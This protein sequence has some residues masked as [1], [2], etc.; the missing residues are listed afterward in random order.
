MSGAPHLVQNAPH[1][2]RLWL[3]P[4][5]HKF[6]FQPVAL[7]QPFY[8]LCVCLYRWPIFWIL[9]RRVLLEK[10]VRITHD[11][12][13]EK[14]LQLTLNN[15]HCSW[16]IFNLCNTTKGGLINQWWLCRRS[17]RFGSPV[18]WFCCLLV[19]SQ[20][21]FMNFKISNSKVLIFLLL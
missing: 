4:Q 9:I 1:A 17:E 5:R 2:P 20:L 18:L 11:Q 3:L 14:V 7:C 15:W 6:R 19:W 12:H 10:P 16:W 13:L 21:W 8:P